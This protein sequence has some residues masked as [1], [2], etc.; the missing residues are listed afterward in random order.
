MI[1]IKSLKKLLESSGAIDL[2]G[3]EAPASVVKVVE[4][5]LGKE[6]VLQKLRRG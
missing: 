1:N 2:L 3:K 5:K 6:Y 4:E